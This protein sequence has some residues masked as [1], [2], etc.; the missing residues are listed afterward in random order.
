MIREQLLKRELGKTN[1]FR[2]RSYM[3]T[4]VVMAVNGM[5]MGARRRKLEKGFESGAEGEGVQS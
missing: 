3:L 1:A 2:C 5:V 4:G